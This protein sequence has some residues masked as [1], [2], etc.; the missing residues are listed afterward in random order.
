MKKIA[1][2]V[3]GNF[4]AGI[5]AAAISAFA[6]GAPAPKGNALATRLLVPRE[7]AGAIT[8]PSVALPDGT[9]T[10]SFVPSGAYTLRIAAAP[11]RLTGC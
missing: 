9:R 11:L 2:V 7:V 5:F 3:L 8:Q 6:L 4:V 1:P 10:V